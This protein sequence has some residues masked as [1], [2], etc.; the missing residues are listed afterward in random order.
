MN[1]ENIIAKL[2]VIYVF[3]IHV[4][5]HSNWMLFIIQLINLLL[6]HILDHRNLKFKYLI[7]DIVIDFLFFL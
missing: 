4:K 3:N 2:H 5:F 6:M 7:D 1:F